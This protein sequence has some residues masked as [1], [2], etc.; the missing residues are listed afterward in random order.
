MNDM[1][2]FQT[3]EYK[4]QEEDRPCQPAAKHMEATREKPRSVKRPQVCDLLHHA[5]HPRVA[6][7][8]RANLARIGRVDIAAGRTD[9]ELLVHCLQGAQQ[10]A[11][12]RLTLLEK[13]QHRASR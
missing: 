11:Q 1:R 6:A 8:I 10:R 5:K 3:M 9:G 7:G 13:M 2:S 4:M 12:R